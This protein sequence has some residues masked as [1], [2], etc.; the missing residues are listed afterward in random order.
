MY[1]LLKRN[2]KK[3]NRIKSKNKGKYIFLIVIEVGYVV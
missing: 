1:I 2:N 3:N